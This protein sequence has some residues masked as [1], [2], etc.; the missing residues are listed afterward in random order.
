MRENNYCSKGGKPTQQ[1]SFWRMFL[2]ALKKQSVMVLA[3]YFPSSYYAFKDKA[4]KFFKDKAF[5]FFKNKAEHGRPTL[6]NTLCHLFLTHGSK[7]KVTKPPPFS[8]VVY[9]TYYFLRK[10]FWIAISK[11]IFDFCLYAISIN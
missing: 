3:T 5:K 2:A 7:L 9:E 1:W 4:F 6:P 8:D 11:V 10:F